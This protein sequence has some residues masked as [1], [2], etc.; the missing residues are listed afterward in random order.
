MSKNSEAIHIAVAEASVIIRSGMIA[1]LRRAP[2]LKIHAVE[3]LNFEALEDCI[4]MHTPDILIVNPAFNNHF[5]VDMFRSKYPN[6]KCVALHSSFRDSCLVA[7]YEDTVS[8][9]K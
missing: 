7:K 8:V 9:F 4:R 2:G 1:V 3:I 5:D 6:I